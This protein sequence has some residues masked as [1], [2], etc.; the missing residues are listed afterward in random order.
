VSVVDLLDDDLVRD[1]RADF[2]GSISRSA[3]AAPVG[4]ARDVARIV[5]S[6]LQRI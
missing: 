5:R 2:P 1:E 4:A 6:D 3:S